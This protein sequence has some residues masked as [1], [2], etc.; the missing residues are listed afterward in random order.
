MSD[1]TP[2]RGRRRTIIQ[3][4]DLR[5]QESLRALA[6]LGVAADNVHFLGYP[7]QGLQSLWNDNWTPDH[8][9][10]SR[11]TR[12]DHAPYATVFHTANAAYCGQSVIDDIKATLRA[13]QPT[14]VTVTH[15]AEDHADHAA[16][17]AFVARALQELQADPHDA[18]WAA[19]TR[20]EYYLVHRGDWPLPA[21]RE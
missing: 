4:A 10:T 18:T 15:P 6:N 2:A 17:A 20:L 12:C 13:F 8:L 21:S 14:L 5:Q 19:Q 16:T 1:R 3:F 9:Y 7:D 11:T